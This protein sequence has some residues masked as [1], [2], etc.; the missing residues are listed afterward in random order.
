M[1]KAIIL[2]LVFYISVCITSNL[3]AQNPTKK[4]SIAV[5]N[6]DTKGL[7]LDPNQMSNLVRVSLE[8]LDR[9]EVMD[10]YEVINIIEKSNLNVANCYGKSCLV[11]LGK[12]LK[13]DYMYTGSAELIGQTILLTFKLINVQTDAVELTEVMEFLNL[14]LELPAMT[15]STIFKMFKKPVN[16][17]LL[18]RLTKKFDYENS[19]NNPNKTYLN[20]Q[21]ARFGYAVVV[22]HMAERMRASSEFGG[23]EANPTLFQFGYQFEKQYLNEGKFQALF[24]F[25]PMISGIE[26]EMFIP[27]FTFLNGFRNNVSGWE[28][29]I[30]PSFGFSRM[31]SRVNIDGNFYSEEQIKKST[32]LSNRVTAE[33]LKYQEVM[34][35]DGETSIATALVIAF[36][37]SFKSGK[38]NIPLNV[39]TT[40]PTKDGFRVGVSLGYNAKR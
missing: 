9:F 6:I 12:S 21:G 11:E 7:P 19:I 15:E 17:E 18:T 23:Y 24:E 27:S 4:P 3:S 31:A 39:W 5:L 22:G 28:I 36:G 2:A 37:K 33:N 29:A 32:I 10:R 8:K 35:R 13:A 1:K 40:I 26:Q 20:L 30:G 34:D 14:P 25:L 38:L 16:Q